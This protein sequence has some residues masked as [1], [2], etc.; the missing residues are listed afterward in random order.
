MENGWKKTNPHN[1]IIALHFLGWT[2]E[3]KIEVVDTPPAAGPPDRAEIPA[4]MSSLIC[5]SAK[6]ELATPIQEER[7]TKV[8]VH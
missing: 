1:Q 4:R 6:V 3:K 7:R 2:L 5:A 8:A